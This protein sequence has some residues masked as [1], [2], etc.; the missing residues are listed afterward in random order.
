LGTSARINVDIVAN[1]DRL[2]EILFESSSAIT[3][4]RNAS[5]MTFCKTTTPLQGLASVPSMNRVFG[6]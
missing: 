3:V 2:P 5:A 4:E 1:T 6:N